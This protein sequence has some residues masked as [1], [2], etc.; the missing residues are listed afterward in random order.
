MEPVQEEQNT[1]LKLADYKRYLNRFLHDRQTTLF[2]LFDRL[3]DFVVQEEY[4]A[5]KALLEGLLAT[6]LNY[7]EK[8]PR[9]K[10]KAFLRT[11]LFQRL[12]LNEFGPDKVLSRCV[13]LKWTSSEIKSFLGKR[14][15]HN[16]FRSL[17]LSTLGVVVDQDTLQVTRDELPILEETKLTLS[18]FNPL[19]FS[20]WRRFFWYVNRFSKARI[21]EGRQRHARDAV[22][23]SLITSIFPRE[24]LCDNTFGPPREVKF[25]DFI[26]DYFQFSHGHSTPRGLLSFLNHA[27][28]SVRRY[29]DENRDIRTIKLDSKFE[30]P[31]FVK[32]AIRDAYKKYGRD[33]W[34][35]QFHW[36]K[37]KK[38]LIAELQ[39][40]SQKGSFSFVEFT[41]VAN[42]SEDEAK[43][44]LAFTTQTGLTKCTNEREK[45]V[46]RAYRF[47]LLF[48]QS[49][50]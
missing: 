12:D 41:K 10:I 16:L 50:Q 8:C 20:H 3:D 43:Q 40:L 7:R 48:Q 21:G 15:A 23:E 49:F 2:I 4:S 27:L 29:Y 34:E 37:E 1:I 11:D 22:N 24:I 38:Y 31:L 35:I 44:F 47:P 39:K 28:D 45:H 5:Q 36:A 14:I 32:T 33:A 6:Q 26:E 25:L 42:I 19:K 46:N 18:N 30:Y 17:K 9:I 13:E